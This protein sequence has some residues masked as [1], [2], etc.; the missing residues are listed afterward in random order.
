MVKGLQ[1]L[2]FTEKYDCIWVQWVFSHLNDQ[3]AV[4]FLVRAKS[5]LTEGGVIVLKENHCNNG[6]VVDK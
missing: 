1:E 3:D 4:K 2:E 6:F 5:A